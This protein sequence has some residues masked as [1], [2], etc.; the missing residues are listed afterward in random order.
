MQNI[1]GT[2]P[3][4]REEKVSYMP[5]FPVKKHSLNRNLKEEEPGQPPKSKNN[6]KNIISSHLFLAL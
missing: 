6:T 3:L 2:L 1:A 5:R 4:N